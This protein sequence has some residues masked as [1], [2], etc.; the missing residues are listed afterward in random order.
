MHPTHHSQRPYHIHNVHSTL[1]TPLCLQQP[2]TTPRRHTRSGITHPDI[3]D[4]P[5]DPSHLASTYH[6]CTSITHDPHCR[7]GAL[8][9]PTNTHENLLAT[10]QTHT[11]PHHIP[12][13]LGIHVY[14]H[15][16][17]HTDR[18]PASQTDRQTTSRLRITCC[19]LSALLHQPP[20]PNMPSSQTSSTKCL[21]TYNP[22]HIHAAS[23]LLTHSLV[24]SIMIPPFTHPRTHTHSWNCVYSR[25]SPPHLLE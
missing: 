21:H 14:T 17:T 7:H 9:T 10:S 1:F 15:P 2:M 24:L 16:Y 18:Q 20:C 12:T 11:T 4:P 13:R 6:S 25:R 5:N 8:L 23:S 3:N 22:T 19:N